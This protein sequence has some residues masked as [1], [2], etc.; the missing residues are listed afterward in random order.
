[1]NILSLCDGISC[2]RIALDRAQINVENYFASEI[3]LA[4]INISKQNYPDI[5]QVGDMNEL[6]D[7]FLATLPRIDLI[8]A[9]TPCQNLSITVINDIKHN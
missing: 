1:M 9:G 4:A 7:D 5:I 2:G 8:M 6:S 3:N